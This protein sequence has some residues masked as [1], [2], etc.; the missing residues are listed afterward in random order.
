MEELAD[1]LEVVRAV[2]AARGSSIPDIIRNSRVLSSIA[3]SDP[4]LEM[5]GRTFVISSE[6]KALCGRG[7][8]I[9]SMRHSALTL[10]MND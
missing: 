6:E 10:N 7:A 4:E 1:L 2:V 9:C 3:E 5:T 8:V